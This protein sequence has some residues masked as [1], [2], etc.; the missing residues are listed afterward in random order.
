MKV[1]IEDDHMNV[2][3]MGGRTVG[4]E[5]AWD[6][7][8]AYLGAVYSREDRHLRRLG[9]IAGLEDSGQRTVMNY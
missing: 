2:L 1:G 5:V 7:A 4:S 3:C 9:K 8:Q 6:L